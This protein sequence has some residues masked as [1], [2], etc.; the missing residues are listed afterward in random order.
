MK[1]LQF[2]A[3]NT[4]ILLAAEGEAGQLEEGLA[5]A[6]KFIRASETRFSRFSEASELSALNRSAGEWF[7]A[8]ADLFEVIALARRFYHVT[9]GLFDPSI[10]PDL[11]RAGYD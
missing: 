11:R 8:S 7:Q 3:M 2:R 1:T 10:L 4:D 5:Q 9:R 6:E